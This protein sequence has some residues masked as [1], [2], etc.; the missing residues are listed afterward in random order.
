MEQ[1]MRFGPVGDTEKKNC[2]AD[3]EQHF[4]LVFSCFRGH[5]KFFFFFKFVLNFFKERIG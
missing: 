4:R 3:Y 2:G 5:L 1:N